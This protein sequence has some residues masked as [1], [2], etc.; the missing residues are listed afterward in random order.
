LRALGGFRVKGRGGFGL[1]TDFYAC[2]TVG[3]PDT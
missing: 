3:R 2:R 1:R